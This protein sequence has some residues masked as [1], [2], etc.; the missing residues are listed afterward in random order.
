MDSPQDGIGDKTL[1]AL[2][3]RQT[4]RVPPAFILME[5]ILDP[6][7]NSGFGDHRR[8]PAAD[9]AEPDA[10]PLA[11]ASPTNAAVVRTVMR[12]P[13][14]F[15]LTVD[16]SDEDPVSAESAAGSLL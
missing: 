1:G 9:S 10:E 6:H 14:R 3:D 16:D 12:E 4:S 15:D 13:Q 11:G 7:S 8:D 2:A 5:P